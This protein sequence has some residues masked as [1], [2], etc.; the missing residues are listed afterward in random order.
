MHS[1]PLYASSESREVLDF[2]SLFSLYPSSE[3]FSPF[4]GPKSVAESTRICLK[5]A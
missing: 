4:G 1:A 5:S 2:P 3:L